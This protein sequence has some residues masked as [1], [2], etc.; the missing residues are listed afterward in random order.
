MQES[1]PHSTA[2]PPRLQTARLCLRGFVESD[3]EGLYA[4]HSNPRAMRYWSFPAW[5]DASQAQGYFVSALQGRDPGRMLCWAITLRGADALIGT[6]TLASI[7]RGQGRAEIGYA[8]HPDRW[9]QGL[10]QEAVHAVLGHAFD[11]LGLRRVE[12]DIDPRNAASCRLAE[13][14]GF[15]REGLLR[16]RWCVAGEVTDSAIYGVLAGDWRARQGT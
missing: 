1:A 16:E 10:A 5:T 3:F 14:M 6:A 2:Q 13:R 9:G 8:L 7:D 11:G 15:I 12:A 4:L